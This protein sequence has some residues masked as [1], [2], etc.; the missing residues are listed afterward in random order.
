[1]KTVQ[2][3]IERIDAQI[4]A[5]EQA[6]EFSQEETALKHKREGALAALKELKTY[7]TDAKWVK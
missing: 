4:E 2:Q 3:I 6:L 7:I 5:F 1:M